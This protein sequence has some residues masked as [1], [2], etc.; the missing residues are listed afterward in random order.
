MKATSIE[1]L[2][3]YKQ[4]WHTLKH[5]GYIIHLDNYKIKEVESVYKE[6]LD[7]KYSVSA[8][9]QDCV[10]DMF[11]RIYT[12]YEKHIQSQSKGI[13]EAALKVV[14]DKP[15]KGRPKKNG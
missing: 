5:A 6:E 2:E 11:K 8:W 12:H 7:P 1:I 3:R 15:K 4:H 13:V 10:G 14:E 9:C